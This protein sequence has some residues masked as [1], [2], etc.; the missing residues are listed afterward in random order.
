[1]NNK[2]SVLLVFCVTLLLIGLQNPVVGAPPLVKIKV[3]QYA[4]ALELVMP[5]GGAWFSGKNSGKL[6][7]GKTYRISGTMKNA[8]SK[9]FHLMV[10]SAAANK[11]QL[12]VEMEA[13]FAAHKIHRFYVGKAPV[14]GFPDN[15]S[16]FI[17]VGIYDDEKL[18]REHQDRLA[19]QNISSWVF[20]ENIKPAQGTLTLS[21]GKKKLVVTATD[22]QLLA[23]GHTVLK[24]AEFARGYSWHGFEDRKYASRLFISWGVENAIDCVEQLSLEKLIVGIVP[25]EIS[26]KAPKSALQA[27]AVAARGEMLSKRG[28]R[29]L[30]EGFDFCSEQHCQVYKG[31]QSVDKYIDENI[32]DTYGLIMQ[33]HEG[34]ILDAVYG[35]NCG[36]HSAANHQIWTSN[37]DPHLQGVP[38]VRVEAAMDLTNEK[39]VTDFIV[40][41]PQ[42]WC[43]EPGIEGSDKFRWKKTLNAEEWKKVEAAAAVGKIKEIGGFVREISGRIVS[44]KLIGSDNE[45]TILK[46]LPIRKLFGGLRSSCF[47]VTWSRDKAGFINGADFS[48]AGWGHGVGMCQTGAQSRAKA[49]QDFS[50]ILLHYFPGA[51]IKKL[52]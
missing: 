7:A 22:L 52:Y 51:I 1:M 33:N 21:L 49:G 26:S 5:E 17:G 27:Q 2:L 38:D 48:G 10:G 6:L 46:E 30:N 11:E 39:V 50:T 16:V 3:A 28:V 31:L 41:P 34:G 4:D 47:A 23:K 12:L 37:P 8:A 24:K 32:S 42:C 25:S 14:D 13:K 40:N 19:A 44:V 15:R 45:K 43:S 18:A 9:R 35:A 20:V 29:H 36:G